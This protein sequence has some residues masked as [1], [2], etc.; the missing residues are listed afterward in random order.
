MLTV[1]ETAKALQVS[2]GKLYRMMNAGI[3]FPVPVNPL[4]ERPLRHYFTR[5]EVERVKRAAG[6]PQTPARADH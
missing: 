1:I 2:R 5:A 6:V 4:L 3:I